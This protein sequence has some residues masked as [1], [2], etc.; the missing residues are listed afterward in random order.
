M[1]EETIL[2][3]SRNQCSL[4]EIWKRKI[5]DELRFST[6]VIQLLEIIHATT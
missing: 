1:D 3:T 4:F 2:G 6:P 5:T